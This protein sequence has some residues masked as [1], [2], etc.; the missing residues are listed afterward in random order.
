M[1]H[2]AA[3]NEC[4]TLQREMHFYDDQRMGARMGLARVMDKIGFICASTMG[5]SMLTPN[6]LNYA[7]Y[8]IVHVNT[9][10]RY[11]PNE[12]MRL[13]PKRWSA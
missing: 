12:L 2:A 3:G 5:T 7:Q 1:R 10:P 4:A 9:I 8:A 13:E 6:R 11:Q